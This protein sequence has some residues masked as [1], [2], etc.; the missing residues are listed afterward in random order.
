MNPISTKHSNVLLKILSSLLPTG[1][2]TRKPP[3]ERLI[4]NDQMDTFHERD[5]ITILADLNKTTASDGFQFKKSN[6]HALFYNLVFA[7]ETK[8]P[9]IL[10]WIKVD[11]DLHVQLQYNGI[12]LPQWFVERHNTRL[13]KVNML[14]NLPAHIRNVA[15]DNCSELLDKLNK[16]QFL[17]PK[18]RPPYSVEMIRYGLRL[19]HTSFQAYKQWLEKFSL[20]SIS[21]LNKIQQRGV[22]S[23]KA[24]KILRE[25]GKISNEMVDKM[26]LEKAT[27]YH[28]DEYVGADNE[29]NLYKGRVAFM[30][31]GLK[32]LIPYIVQAIP[33]DKFSGE[34][35]ANKMSNCILCTRYR[36]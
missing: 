24:L 35:L 32:E 25:N 34:W 6:D 29:G 2:T 15:F 3:R 23:I 11:S 26:Y 17:K 14:E 30:I 22:N 18:G 36:Q 8:S 31:V 33:E 12:P 27:H 20:P 16:R 10:E 7:K 21:L 4:S 13:K 5:A 9:K 28:S 19:R 1:K